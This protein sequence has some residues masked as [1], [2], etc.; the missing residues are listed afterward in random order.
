[1]KKVFTF[2]LDLTRA[3]RIVALRSPVLRAAVLWG[4]QFQGGSAGA[5]PGVAAVEAVVVSVGVAF[6]TLV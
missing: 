4:I 5:C 6:V 2:Q 3:F 1:M